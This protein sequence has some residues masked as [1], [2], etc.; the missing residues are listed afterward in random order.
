[1]AYSDKVID[2]YENPRN[3]GSLDKDDPN[4]DATGLMGLPGIT[5]EIRKHLVKIGERDEL[6]AEDLHGQ[7]DTPNKLNFE[8]MKN[9]VR[10]KYL[11][12]YWRTIVFNT[13]R[14]GLN[15]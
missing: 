10:A 3:V 15:E 8:F 5:G 14:V 6:I 9:H 1:M 4:D 2:H 13:I 7:A 11:I 12:W